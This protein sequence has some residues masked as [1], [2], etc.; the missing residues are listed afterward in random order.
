MVSKYGK[1]GRQD[2]KVGVGKECRFPSFS[3]FSE[4]ELVNY[5]QEKKVID[6]ITIRGI[7]MMTQDCLFSPLVLWAC[8]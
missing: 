3:K 1:E 4:W 7:T 5:S 2:G 6:V 8:S